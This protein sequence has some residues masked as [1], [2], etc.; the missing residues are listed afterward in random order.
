M[1][2]FD[3]DDVK[4]F[5]HDV[6][7]LDWKYDIYTQDRSFERVTSVEQIV[8]KPTAFKVY[9]NDQLGW[10]NFLISNNSFKT[11]IVNYFNGKKSFSDSLDYTKIWLD[12]LSKNK[13]I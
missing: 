4:L 5:L 11:L 8:N 13:T 10:I 2:N 12:Y 7:G 6:V 3:L 9:K 1:E